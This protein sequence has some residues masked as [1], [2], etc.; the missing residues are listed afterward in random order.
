VSRLAHALKGGCGSLGAVEMTRSAA[1][2]E[3]AGASG[4]LTRVPELL[5]RLEK[6]FGRAR[7]A[8]DGNF[9]AGNGREQ[10]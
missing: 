4:D 2:L 7:A 5:D 1:E 3:A 6:D 9:S 8:L 10:S